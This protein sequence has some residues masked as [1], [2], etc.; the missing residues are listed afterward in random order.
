MIEQITKQ[1]NGKKIVLNVFY[2]KK[3]GMIKPC[4]YKIVKIS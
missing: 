4:Y 3:D 1:I 2:I